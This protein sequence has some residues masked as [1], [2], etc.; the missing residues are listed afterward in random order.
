MSEQTIQIVSIKG[1]KFH[2]PDNKVFNGGSNDL[3]DARLMRCGRSLVPHNFFETLSD[4]DRYTGGRL[5][6]HVCWQCERTFTHLWRV[7]EVLSR[8]RLTAN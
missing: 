8:E 1:G 6:H 4:A 2:R 5:E 3:R 7:P